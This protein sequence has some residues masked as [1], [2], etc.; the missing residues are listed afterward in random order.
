[1]PAQL[2]EFMKDLAKEKT[3]AKGLQTVLN[4][5][6]DWEG[7]FSSRGFHRFLSTGFISQEAKKSNPG[8][9]HLFMFYPRA[10]DQ[11]KNNFDA[12]LARMRDLFE[13]DVD[14]ETISYYSKQGYYAAT[15]QHNLRIQLQTALDILSLLLGVG[16]IA[17]QGLAYILEPRRWTGMSM[18]F[19]ERFRSEAFF[20]PK[21]IYCI[22]QSSCSSEWKIFGIVPPFGRTRS[23][24]RQPPSSTVL[25]RVS[26]SPSGIPPP[27][28]PR[29]PPPRP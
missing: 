3:A 26:I 17:T 1:M 6:R 25:I 12:A 18:H 7:T 22:D 4:E 27:F 24:Q 20:G 5:A 14:E 29:P 16:S 8:G 13:A 2:T 11:G 21:F 15:N 9:V 28:S 10:V 19:H 23:P